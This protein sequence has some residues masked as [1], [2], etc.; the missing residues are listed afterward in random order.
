MWVRLA[1]IV[2]EVWVAKAASDFYDEWK[3]K[4]GDDE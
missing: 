3:K 4:K 2:V 1:W